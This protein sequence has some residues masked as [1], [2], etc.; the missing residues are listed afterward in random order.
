MSGLVLGVEIGGTKLQAALGRR[1]GTILARRRGIAPGGAD[2]RSIL[3]WFPAPLRE[4]AGEA[5][6]AGGPVEGIGVGFGGPIDTARG[7]T[8]KSHQVSGWDDFPLRDWFAEETKLPTAVMNDSNAAG[9]AEYLCGSGKGTR[10]F[11]YMNVG[12]GIGGA[13]I[14]DGKLHDGQGLG[15]FEM[16]HTRIG[17]IAPDG[18]LRHTK[19]EDVCSGWAI[20]RELRAHPPVQGTALYRLCGGDVARLTCAMLG[21]AAREGHGDAQARI[22]AVAERLARAVANAITLIHPERFAVGGGVGLLGD[23][24]LAPLRRHIDEYVFEPYRGRYEI[25]PAALGEDVVLAGTLA[26]A[27][28]A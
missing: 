17:E 24:L 10:T 23:A 21:E 5:K 20:E 12:S 18:T 2:A 3:E 25:V 9:W 4:L 22:D 14:V 6:R 1:D 11:C 27:G 28:G 8:V 15:A 19:L 7:Q 26:L 16:G 13:L